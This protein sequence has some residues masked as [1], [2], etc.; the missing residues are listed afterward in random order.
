MVAAMFVMTA[1][2]VKFFK[3]GGAPENY[4]LVTLWN[5]MQLGSPR[6]SYGSH[7]SPSVNLCLG[8]PRYQI[9]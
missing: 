6:V 2:V 9:F 3:R 7:I 4:E 1:A 5:P 8:T